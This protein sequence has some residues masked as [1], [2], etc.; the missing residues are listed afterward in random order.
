[1]KLLIVD[2]H[3]LFRDGLK[4]L[5]MQLAGDVQVLEAPD[6]TSAF[7]TLS[8]HSDIDFMLLDLNLPGQDGLAILEAMV[9]TYPT[10]P[11]AIVS[12]STQKDDV[13]K[14]MER[15]AMGYIFK[16]SASTV[17]LGAVRL[18]LAGGL[19]TPPLSLLC[20][21]KTDISTNAA[22]VKAL[23][24]R[25][26]EVLSLLVAG[27]SNK[28]IASELDIAEATI[29]MHITAIFRALGVTNRTQAALAAEHV[30]T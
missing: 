16:H 6:S 10:I 14:V 11:V 26:T 24:K 20:T 23:T 30:F 3:A 25:Q 9:D 18:M 1:M 5:L 29:K 4:L 8:L 19:Y 17:I 27:F 28:Q 12:A 15:S 13:D 2:D 22:L 21:T 7:D